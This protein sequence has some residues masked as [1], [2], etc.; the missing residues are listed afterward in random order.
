MCI[1]WSLIYSSHYVQWFVL[2]N[3]P[4]LRCMFIIILQNWNHKAV[5]KNVKSPLKGGYV[6]ISI[7]PLRS[8][9]S[10]IWKISCSYRSQ[11]SRNTALRPLE[12]QNIYDTDEARCLSNDSQKISAHF[13]CLGF[14]YSPMIVTKGQL[15]MRRFSSFNKVAD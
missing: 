10:I 1:I 15:E 14:L 12:Q 9:S 3:F 7:H 6:G 2:N 5:Y 13:R 4:F 8:Y 11:R